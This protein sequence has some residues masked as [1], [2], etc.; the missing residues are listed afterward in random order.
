MFEMNIHRF[1]TNM[2]YSIYSRKYLIESRIFGKQYVE[3]NGKRHNKDFSTK[4]ELVLRDKK[5]HFETRFI[6][7]IF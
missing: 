2:L 1:I 4:T 6:N 7:Q 5:V 3:L